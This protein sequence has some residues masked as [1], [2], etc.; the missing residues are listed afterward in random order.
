M[1]TTKTI[2]AAPATT[3][4]ESVAG[5]SAPARRAMPV[6]LFSIPLGLAG[7]GGAW[8]AA[9]R[10]LGASEVPADIAYAASTVVYVV[11][12]AVY[13]VGTVRHEGGG[14]HV[15]LRH[16]LFGPL[17]AYLP[18]IAILLVAHYAPDLGDATR[19]PC[20]A[21][22]A[23][24]S[25]NAA[26]LLAHWL[27]APLDP[28]TLHPGYFLPVVAGPFIA[29]IGLASVGDR[30]AA[31]AVFGVGAYFWLLLGAISTGRL[32][33]GSPLPQP[34]LPVLS[35]LLSPPATASLAWFAVMGGQIDQV[36]A[37]VGAITLLT[38]LSQL[39]FLPDY[40]RLPFSSQHWVFTFPLAVLGNIGI[41][42]R[43]VGVH[44]LAAR[45]L[46][47]S[48]GL[49]GRHPRD[50]RWHPPR[51]RTMALSPVDTPRALLRQPRPPRGHPA[52]P[53]IRPV[54][55]RVRP[56]PLGAKVVRPATIHSPALSPSV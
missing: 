41:R 35:I 53:V 25:I 15:H 46:G 16:P 26:A 52:P 4:P 10:L 32:F 22:V 28:N 24:L 49:H 2:P 21:A 5:S 11:F 18:V 20:Y 6:A 12:T 33:F 39:F 7:L 8:S 14:F 43:R 47:S 50:P 55:P 48:R 44:R 56:G 54:I 17:T 1:S 31:V 29:S 9:A 37:A 13:V 27:R 40:L 38:L 23:A 42:C 51:L 3:V 34:F 36:Q 30:M 45:R 19:W